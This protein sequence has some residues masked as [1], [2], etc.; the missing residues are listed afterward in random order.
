MA[1]KPIPQAVIRAAATLTSRYG[2]GLRY[3]GK[4]DGNPVYTYEPDSPVEIGAVRLVYDGKQVHEYY[5][6]DAVRLPVIYAASER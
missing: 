6:M 3:V 4:L 5:G 2:D 1:K